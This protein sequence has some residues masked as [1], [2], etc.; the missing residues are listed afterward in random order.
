MKAFLALVA[1]ALISAVIWF[2]AA[3]DD[4]ASDGLAPGAAAPGTTS[5][6]QSAVLDGVD[7]ASAASRGELAAGPETADPATD[8]ESAQ[9]V[10]G[11][12]ILPQ[13]VPVDDTLEVFALS[14][15]LDAAQLAAVLDPW[16]DLVEVPE[17]Q[18]ILRERRSRTLVARAPVA[19][20]GSFRLPYG[21]AARAGWL[22][23]RGRHLF[24]MHAMPVDPRKGDTIQVVPDVGFWI[25]GKLTRAGG[26]E[27]S[28]EGIPLRLT[29]DT[30][31]LAGMGFEADQVSPTRM[32]RSGPGGSFAFRAAYPDISYVVEALPQEDLAYGR[33]VLDPQSPGASIQ[34]EIQL[35][36]GGSIQGFV[37]DS[38]GKTIADAEV[39][40]TRA[41]G[42]LGSEGS[43]V[44][45]TRSTATGAFTLE[46]V[47]VEAL[48]LTANHQDYLQTTRQSVEVPPT[49]ALDGVSLVLKEG[50]T[51]SGSV[52]WADG[53]PAAGVQ[54]RADFDVAFGVG[55]QA[56]A[57]N[58][59][60][61]ASTVADGN[62][63]FVLRGLGAGPFS[64]RA[65]GESSGRARRDGVRPGQDG[66]ELILPPEITV[67][68]RVVDQE[69]APVTHFSLHMARVNAGDI[70]RLMGDAR[71]SDVQSDA[72]EFQVGDLEEGTWEIQVQGD[73]LISGSPTKVDLPRG[74]GAEPLLISLVRAATVTGRVL[75]PSGEAI[76]AAKVYASEGGPGWQSMLTEAAFAPETLSDEEGAYE[77]T[78]IPPGGAS[79]VAEHQ[80]FAASAA[81]SLDLAAGEQRP[82]V[83][84]T[85]KLGGTI[86]GEILRPDGT[87][88]SGYL[89]NGN[90]TA[91][92]S[93][94]NTS[95]GADGTFR[96]EH[97][98]EG[99]W[100]VVGIDQ[101]ADW[102]GI[103]ESGGVDMAAMMKDILIGQASV[104]DGETVHV[105]LGSAPED[106]VRVTGKVT[107]NE[108]P[109]EGAILSFF[110]EGA[111]IYERL[112]FTTVAGDGSYEVVLDQGG[113]YVI[114]VQ[115]PGATMMQQSTIE[116][117][118]RIPDAPEHKLDL[119]LPL[120]RISGTVTDSSG[121]PAGGERVTLT[122]D[123]TARSDNL[124]GGQYAELMTGTD[125]TYDMNGLRP[126]TYRIS[127]G[128]APPFTGEGTNRLGRVSVGGIALGEDQWKQG[129]D[130]SLP[131]PG[132]LEVTITDG[133]GTPLPGA[134]LFVRDGG[135]RILEPLSMVASDGSGVAEYRG[136]APGD[137]TLTARQGSLTSIETGVVRVKAGQATRAALVLEPGT[138]LWLSFTDSDRNPKAATVSV[139]DTDG[140]EYSG[141]VG[142]AD[143]QAL[144]IEGEFSPAEHRL[145]PL[146]PGKYIV[147]AHADGLSAEKSVRLRGDDEKRLTVRLK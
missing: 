59:G 43:T 53:R 76:Q 128:G 136:V 144:Y 9:W 106:P 66:L 119:E 138:V 47:P 80:D 10:E 102:S 7:P 14:A 71:R 78:G 74:D 31:N 95:S 28:V 85:L 99:S 126:G 109:V 18:E 132:S 113:S 135:G 142:M 12:V 69:G 24:K 112:K 141:M 82:D 116:F 3:P 90:N 62:G 110:P 23:L 117:S 13:G 6:A 104:V 115:R 11:Q 29:V 40:A 124:L 86:T 21:P 121:Q 51:I 52:R 55:M 25:Q 22:S 61:K 48:K 33:I 19:A 1:L 97:V 93:I 4:N 122:V 26:A 2:V 134:T 17:H 101:S 64:V 34:T 108:E 70:I 96:F 114:S 105:I 127:A 39:I 42:A 38:N 107:Q 56:M 75:S 133:Q 123:G 103:T 143:L 81:R 5:T 89:V 32:E 45:M 36:A 92:Q 72:G 67:A 91:D 8:L 49:G 84:L 73:G 98:P 68:G 77:L 129:M 27:G 30:S 46:A 87:P 83:D 140:R 60:A 41:G 100:Q 125:G 44:R 20:D 137:Y 63:V 120:G 65:K 50:E 79:L 37:V 35:G 130:L 118:R 16:F 58:H 145:G 111:G 146:P 131:E 57:A 147:R 139:T 88:G 94:I 15:D 54:V